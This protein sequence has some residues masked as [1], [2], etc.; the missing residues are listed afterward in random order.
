MGLIGCKDEKKPKR[1]K[2]TPLGGATI[3]LVSTDVGQGLGLDAGLAPTSTEW[4]DVLVLGERS[5]ILVGR[6][7]DEA[8][9]LR[10]D[11]GGR[12]WKALKAP[13]EKWVAWGAGED[14]ALSFVTGSP[15]EGTVYAPGVGI[16]SA[17]LRFR[18]PVGDISEPA[19]FFGKEEPAKGLDLPGGYG[20]PATLDSELASM[21]LAKGRAQHLVY[22]VPGGKK[23]PDPVALPRGRFVTAPYGHPAQLVSVEGL[24]VKWRPWPKPDE[25]LAKDAK[26]VTGLRG[27]TLLAKALDQGPSCVSGPWA[28]QQVKLGAVASVVGISPEKSAVIKLPSGA[29]ETFGCRKDAIVVETVDPKKKGEPRLVRCSTD[30]A[31]VEPKNNPFEVWAGE[32]EQKVVAVPTAKGV[33]AFLQQN[34]GA[35]WKL[36]LATS[37]DGGETFEL[38]RGVGEGSTE[39]GTFAIGAVV[40]FPE[41]VLLLMSATVTGQSQRGWYVLSSDDGGATWGQP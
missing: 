36:E 12:S 10:T 31:C 11:D 4:T 35:R 27:S 19:P 37:I 32:H 13:A 38:A 5:A 29:K 21:V 6:A 14:A 41:R 9:A 24:S 33:V 20:K 23:Q 28:Y 7:L 15:K 3:D 39:R 25:E 18:S 1:K 40:A 22:G 16:A 17:S 8:I 34:E 30:G 2:A 26:T